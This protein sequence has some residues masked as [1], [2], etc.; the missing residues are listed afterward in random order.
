MLVDKDGTAR[1]VRQ[2]SYWHGA[3]RSDGKYIIAD[4]MQGR[5]WLIEV[6]TGNT[7]LLATGLRG[8]VRSIHPHPSF[9]RLGRYVQFHSGRT[10]ETV[11][12]IDLAEFLRA[13]ATAE[14][15]FGAC[16]ENN[17]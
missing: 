6:A 7:Y 8:Q 15:G 12:I 10:H 17:H 5:L 1:L 13:C 3:A 16:Q 9:D 14:S 2:G 4:D 11:A